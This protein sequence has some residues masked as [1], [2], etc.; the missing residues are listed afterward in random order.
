MQSYVPEGRVAHKRGEAAQQ[1]TTSHPADGVAYLNWAGAAGTPN[2][3]F[4]DR[5]EAA[6]VDEAGVAAHTHHG[7][8]M[9]TK[10]PANDNAMRRAEGHI[11]STNAR[12]TNQELAKRKMDSCRKA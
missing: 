5:S 2:L 7:Q 12:R 11:F 9:H 4:A 8:M 3:I 10:F 6:R 1:T